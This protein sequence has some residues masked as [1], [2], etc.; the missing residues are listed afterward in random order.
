MQNTNVTVQTSLMP[1]KRTFDT[2]G[3]NQ[4]KTLQDVIDC[5]VPYNFKDCKLVVTHNGMVVYED[6]SL[7][8]LKEDD[9]IGLNFVPMGGGGGGKNTVMMIGLVV[10]AIALPWAAA[11]AYGAMA[12]TAAG[13]FAI[14]GVSVLGAAAYGAVMIGGSL[15]LSMAQSAL[16]STPKQRSGTNTSESQTFF[17]EGARNTINKYGVIPINLG[18]NRIFPNQAALPFTETSAN[19][20]DQYVR[21]LFTYGY[22]KL[23]ITER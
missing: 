19:G 1:F 15:L 3:L 18:T 8:E 2:I 17:I 22:G 6:Y 20:K 5:T 23:L 13:S 9:L 21:Q 12:A 16:M 10:A 11:A 14:G 7:V 4:C